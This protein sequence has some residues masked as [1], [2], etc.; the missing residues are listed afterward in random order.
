MY[1]PKYRTAVPK[2]GTHI[3][4]FGTELSTMRKYNCSYI[5][6]KNRLYF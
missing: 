6:T 3:P 2:Y 4:N 5:K 1:I